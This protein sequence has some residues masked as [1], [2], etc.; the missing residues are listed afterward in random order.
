MFSLL[1]ACL[2]YDPKKKKKNSIIK[3]VGSKILTFVRIVKIKGEKKG[4]ELFGRKLTRKW[5]RCSAQKSFWV[6]K[7][8]RLT[9][10][11]ERCVRR[12]PLYTVCRLASAF[13]CSSPLQ[14]GS[15]RLLSSQASVIRWNLGTKLVGIKLQCGLCRC[16]DFLNLFNFFEREWECVRRSVLRRKLLLVHLNVQNV[17]SLDLC[18]GMDSH[19]RYKAENRCL[20]MEVET[21]FWAFWHQPAR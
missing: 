13:R 2:I 21:D 14:A 9:L 18:E 20:L 5:W 6:H 17:L 4:P 7:R 16:Q 19:S 11:E 15:L 1:L 12:A 3:H 8:P 10:K